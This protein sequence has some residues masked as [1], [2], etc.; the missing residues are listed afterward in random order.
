M[1]LFLLVITLEITDRNT[2]SLL[3]LDIIDEKY[4][5]GNFI[6]ILQFSYSESL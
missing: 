3:K 1:K 2:E 5:V 4:H 6:G